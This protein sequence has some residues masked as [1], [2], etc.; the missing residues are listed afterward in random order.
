MSTMAKTKPHVYW[1]RLFDVHG[2]WIA[3]LLV[4]LILAIHVLSR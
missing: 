4:A 3:G 2:W 1:L